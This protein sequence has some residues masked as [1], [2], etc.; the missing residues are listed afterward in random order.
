MVVPGLG[1]VWKR[2]GEAVFR[3]DQ[4]PDGPRGANLPV[5]N[6][7][8]STDRQTDKTTMITLR[9][10]NSEISLRRNRIPNRRS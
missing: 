2:V 4:R 9:L 8:A 5:V 1:Q 6:R 3:G 10:T 7:F